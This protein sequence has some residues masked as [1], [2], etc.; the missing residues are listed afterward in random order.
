MVSQWQASYFPLPQSGDTV[1][2]KV[3]KHGLL[4][5]A[6]IVVTGLTGGVDAN[7]THT[8]LS[9]VDE[10]TFTFKL[11]YMVITGTLNPDAT[12]TL[13]YAGILGGAP[14]WQ[15]PAGGTIIQWS[16]NPNNW[17]TIIEPTPSWVC[18]MGF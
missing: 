1:T 13:P 12:G 2:M 8:V 18:I 10:D 16:G 15:D 7:G 6:S 14:Y 5:G 4:A 17:W 3:S 11:N 9:V